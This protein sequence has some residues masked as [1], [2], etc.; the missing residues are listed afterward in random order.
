ME[1]EHIQA[2]PVEGGSVQHLDGLTPSAI[3]S[4]MLTIPT[5]SVG[6][7]FRDENARLSGRNI[8][9][10]RHQGPPAAVVAQPGIVPLQPKEER[11]RRED[12]V[13]QEQQALSANS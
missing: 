11:L 7:V 2:P 5:L 13:R 9:R 4:P 8:R 10:A 12:M 1:N 3:T 6:T